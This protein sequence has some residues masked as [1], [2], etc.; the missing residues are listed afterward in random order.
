[1]KHK[2]NLESAVLPL[3]N[4]AT[5]AVVLPYEDSDGTKRQQH[6]RAG[7]VGAGEFLNLFSKMT[8]H[9][10]YLSVI[11]P[12]KAFIETATAKGRI[13]DWAVIW[14]QR[15]DDGRELAFDELST[16]API[17]RRG[18]RQPPRIDFTG[19][20]KRN[21]L[22]AQPVASG[23]ALPGLGASDTRG[24]LVISLVADRDET[25]EADAVSRHE[26]VGMIS[27]RVPDKSVQSR[28]DHIQYGVVIS[29][30]P[31]QVAVD[32]SSVV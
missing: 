8:W 22:A 31:D 20:N 25:S 6:A 19:E 5:S 32:A 17:F 30:K 15:T 2:H 13:K 28:R 4:L 21:I 23:K 29:T 14:P 24:V 10:D 12:L 27:L 11:E 1:V 9:Q 26:I 3:L 16:P 7:L 18:R